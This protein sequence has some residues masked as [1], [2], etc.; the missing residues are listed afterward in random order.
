MYDL[1][2]DVAKYPEFLPLC[3]G[4]AIRTRAPTADG[5]AIVATMTVGYKAIRETFTS[6]VALEPAALR[7]VARS[8]DG[9]FRHLENRWTFRDAPGGTCDI[10]FFVS[11]EFK[12]LMLQMLM[13]A[14]FEHAV[15][16]FTEAFEVRAEQVYGAAKTV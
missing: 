12:S 3:E 4:L 11:Y 2:A 8:D 14:M 10:E 1:V 5:E 7:V 16:R 15:R 13:G 6:R 9:P